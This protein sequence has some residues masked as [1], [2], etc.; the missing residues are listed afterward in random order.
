MK[1]SINIEK[2]ISPSPGT[3]ITL[4][5]KN[6]NTIL[7]ATILGEKGVPAEKIG[8]EIAIKILK[9]IKAYSTLDIHAFDQLIP[10]MVLSEFNKQSICI[11]RD[12]S[13]HASTNMWLIGKFL[14]NQ[15]IFN[16]ENTINN[17]IIRING[18]GIPKI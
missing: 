2:V 9:E 12:I 18:L 15:N 14:K 8:E 7:G 6:E 4:W 11:V 1:S 3:G 5:T 16:I 13:S 17:K 10:Y